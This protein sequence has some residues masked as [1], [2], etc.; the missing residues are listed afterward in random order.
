MLQIILEPIVT[1]AFI[2][3]GFLGYIVGFLPVMIGSL[4]SLEPG[5]IE[6]AGDSA[7]YQSKGMKWWHLTYCKHGRTYL[8]AESVALVGL[9][10]IGSL[11]GL[12][13][14]VLKLVMFS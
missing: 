12:T 3:L 8:P 10:L 9:L 6:K 5:P 11:V 1:L 14:L 2:A 4:G 7:F 13:G